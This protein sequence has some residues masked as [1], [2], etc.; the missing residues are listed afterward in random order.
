MAYNVAW[1]CRTKLPLRLRTKKKASEARDD[2]RNRR[3]GRENL[4]PSAQRDF[5]WAFVLITARS[6]FDLSF[7]LAVTHAKSPGNGSRALANYDPAQRILI[8][9]N[10]FG[11]ISFFSASLRRATRFMTERAKQETCHRSLTNSLL[12]LFVSV[13][14]LGNGFGCWNCRKFVREIQWR[15]DGCHNAVIHR[16][17]VG[18]WV[19]A[20]SREL[21][22]VGLKLLTS[23]EWF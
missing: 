16:A 12:Q 11:F 13:L 17:R 15:V 23:S 3:R 19:F 22:F 6:G 8:M 9:L 7:A 10:A 2:K 21:D 20:Q 1:G 5:W 14:V 4:S 18:I